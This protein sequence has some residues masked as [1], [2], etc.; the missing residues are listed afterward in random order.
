MLVA[1]VAVVRGQETTQFLMPMFDTSDAP[2]ASFEPADLT[3]FEDGKEA[4]VLKVEPRDQP[5][6]VTL[7]LDNGRGMAESLVHLRAAAKEFLTRL[8]PGAEVAL[9]TTAPQPRTSV[10]LT[11]NREEVL[12]GI[13]RVAPDSSPGRFI[14][15]LE[16]VADQWSKQPGDYTPVL[17]SVGSTYSAELMN[18]RRVE[19]AFDRAAKARATVHVVMVKPAAAVEGDAQLEIG[20]RIARNTRGRFDEIGS[21]LQFT[22]L[23]DVAATIASG[24]GRQFLVTL[25]RPAGATGR[26]GSLSMSPREGLKP[27]RVTRLP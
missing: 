5:T 27:G 25:Q 24:T 14:E 2:V 7:A 20:Q 15:A 13:D 1:A 4:K 8:P 12:K 23:S 9:M 26:L 22:V 10:R 17:V 19:E 18:Q 3:V 6:R 16:Y 11:K 21:F